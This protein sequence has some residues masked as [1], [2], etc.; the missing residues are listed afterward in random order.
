LLLLPIWNNNAHKKSKHH[1]LFRNFFPTTATKTTVH[2]DLT[3]LSLQTKES[4][5]IHV[6]DKLPEEYQ[7]CMVGINQVL[8]M[9]WSI[10]NKSAGVDDKT[11]LQA[12]ALI[13]DCNKYKMDLTTNGVVITDAIKYVQGKMDHLNKT[14]K[15]LLQD[16]KHKENKTE[17]EVV[18]PETEAEE[19]TTNGVF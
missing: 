18:E 10:V 2:K 11:R 17:G 5:R 12:L 19:K 15:A 4:P 1:K 13:N 7:K 16:I 14:E 8:N 3:Y 6:Q 9:A